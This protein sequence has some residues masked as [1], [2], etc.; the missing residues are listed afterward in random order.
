VIRNAGRRLPLRFSSLNR[1]LQDQ[2]HHPI[3]VLA[4]RRHHYVPIFLTY[5][6]LEVDNRGASI[7]CCQSN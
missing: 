5:L 3:N 7:V 2:P 6:T 4:P 1:Q